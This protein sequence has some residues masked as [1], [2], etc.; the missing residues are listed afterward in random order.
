MIV[1]RASPPISSKS[2]SLSLS[3][4]RAPTERSEMMRT[5]EV[6]ISCGVVV[7]E[8]VSISISRSLIASGGKYWASVL[9]STLFWRAT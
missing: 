1:L 7:K 5:I 8:M 6:S 9:N 4:N 2:I 3:K